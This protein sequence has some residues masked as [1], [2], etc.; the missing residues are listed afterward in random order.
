M[1]KINFVLGGKTGD[2]LIYEKSFNNGTFR[3]RWDNSN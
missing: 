2:L 1:E 3:S